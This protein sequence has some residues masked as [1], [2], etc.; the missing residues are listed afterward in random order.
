MQRA[1][2]WPAMHLWSLHQ[3]SASQMTS[4]V[5][6]VNQGV[7]CLAS[8]SAHAIK[9]DAWLCARYILSWIIP[10]TSYCVS[11]TESCTIPLLVLNL[12]LIILCLHPWVTEN[13]WIQLVR[14]SAVSGGR[15]R[16][17]KHPTVLL[18]REYY[19]KFG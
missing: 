5:R 19:L 10:H 18:V 16:V 11:I 7:R 2:K 8:C 17:I 1:I 13:S 15:V 3:R 14:S 6:Y 12:V 9:S 4:Q